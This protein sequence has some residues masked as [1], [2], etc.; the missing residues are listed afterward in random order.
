M[1]QF[2]VSL[3]NL[4]NSSFEE[5]QRNSTELSTGHNGDYQF[6]LDVPKNNTGNRLNIVGHGD[7]GGSSF[8][9][10]INNVK[11]TP[12]E[13]HHKIKPQFCDKE[14]TSIRLV[15]CRAGGTGFAEALADCTKLPVKASPGSVTI[16]Q[17]C[18]DRY[19]L[20]KKMKSEKRPDEHKFF[21]FECSKDNS[22]RN[23]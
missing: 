4:R 6:F 17:I 21:W 3:A 15:S 18:N 19:V 16:Y 9:S 10:L 11:S 8:V 2:R 23:S 22:V 7:K 1:G 14:I 5:K 20:L 13:L 12:A